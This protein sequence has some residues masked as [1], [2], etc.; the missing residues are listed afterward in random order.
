M[1]RHAAGI[2]EIVDDLPQ[3]AAFYRD[4]L[5]LEVS[6]EAGAGYASVQVPGV[7]H[8][9][10]WQRA[11]AAAVIHGEGAAPERVPLGFTVGFEAASVPRSAAELAQRGAPMVGEVRDEHW[12]QRTARFRT[13]S[14]AVCEL[15]ETPHARRIV[16]DVAAA[17]DA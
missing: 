3:A 16:Q 13:P 8:F 11:S 9:G 4:V 17:D 10:L 14:G 5:G 7:L 1:I 6:L 2:A 12:G 15:S